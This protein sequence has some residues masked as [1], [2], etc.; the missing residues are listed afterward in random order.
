MIYTLIFGTRLLVGCVRSCRR[1]YVF[2]WQ[3]RSIELYT[4]LYKVEW[5]RH[6]PHLCRVG[7]LLFYIGGWRGLII[8]TF[9]IN[10][11]KLRINFS[12]QEVLDV[13]ILMS[14]VLLFKGFCKALPLHPN[15]DS[16]GMQAPFKSVDF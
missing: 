4:V 10:V 12:Q 7:M 14:I 6:H 16:S 3:T 9:S 11:M 8:E 5:K 1:H 13:L 15:K 2:F